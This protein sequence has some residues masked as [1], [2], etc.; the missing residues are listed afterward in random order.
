MTL[1]NVTSHIQSFNQK[2]LNAASVKRGFCFLLVF[3][4][5]FATPTNAIEI[6]L[7]TEADV[8]LSLRQEADVAIDR[9]IFWLSK[10]AAPTNDL[11]TVWL[12][13]YAQLR[14]G[15]NA[16]LTKC[17]LTPF[18]EALPK[19]SV[20]EK[21]LS[22]TDAI[23]T[24]PNDTR[25]LFALQREQSSEKSEFGWR[26]TLLR[27]LVNTQKITATGGNWRSV[28]Q[29]VWGILTLRALLNQTIPILP[30]P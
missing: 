14:S 16:T 6:S 12:W 27:E 19:K 9:A 7:P 18:Q 11:M 28:D 2:W 26:E 15:A 22:L 13:H 23:A 25:Y 29:T 20:D 4:I 24:H 21:S 17:Q 1:R 8:S 3:G 5:S 30:A 10:Q